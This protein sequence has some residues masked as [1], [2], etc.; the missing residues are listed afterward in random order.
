MFVREI[1]KV[2]IYFWYFDDVIIRK[3]SIY[4]LKYLF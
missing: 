2:P 3:E 1:R 4:Y